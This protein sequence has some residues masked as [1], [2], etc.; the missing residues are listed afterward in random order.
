MPHDPEG[1]HEVVQ[2]EGSTLNTVLTGLRLAERVVGALKA[3]R[4]V[5]LDLRGVERLTP[6]FANAVVMTILDAVG[7]DE[8]RSK[9]RVEIASPLVA[10]GWSKAIERYERGIRLTTQRS[11]VA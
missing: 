11:N 8:F 5:F 10:E 2:P 9:L 7:I 1:A 6:S 3:G 4:S